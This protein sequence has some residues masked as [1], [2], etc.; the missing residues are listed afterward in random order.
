R[1]D[2]KSALRASRGQHRVEPAVMTP[3]SSDREVHRQPGIALL[4]W[5]DPTASS[6][7]QC[8]C[9]ATPIEEYEKL[10]IIAQVALYRLDCR[11]RNTGMDG[12][13]PKVHERHARRFCTGGP[14]G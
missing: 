8:R 3:Q 14:I 9:V 12:V 6:T 11:S 4:T 1:L 2:C 5:S 10:A 7:K 13:G